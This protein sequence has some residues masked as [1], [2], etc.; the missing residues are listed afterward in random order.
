M[1]KKQDTAME[2]LKQVRRGGMSL[3]DTLSGERSM[4]NPR[5]VL[6]RGRRSRA[7]QQESLGE[8]T[9]LFGKSG[10]T[11][12]NFAR[13]MAEYALELDD[14]VE[15]HKDL[16]SNWQGALGRMRAKGVMWGLYRSMHRGF[17][18]GVPFLKTYGKN[19]MLDRAERSGGLLDSIIGDT[20]RNFTGA[21]NSIKGSLKQLQTLEADGHSHLD[22]LHEE[23]DHWRGESTRLDQVVLGAEREMETK[24]GEYDTLVSQWEQMPMLND[25]EKLARE[26]FGRSVTAAQGELQQKELT[27][28]NL[29]NERNRAD[30][31]LD[32]SENSSRA[33]EATLL[34]VQS[35]VASYEMMQIGYEAQIK[36]SMPIFQQ[37]GKT[38]ASAMH[39]T[40]LINLY[41]RTMKAANE[42]MMMNVLAARGIAHEAMEMLAKPFFDE[43]VVEQVKAYSRETQDEQRRFSNAY[44]LTQQGIYVDPAYVADP[45]KAEKPKRIDQILADIERQEKE[46]TAPQGG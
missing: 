2:D 38:A 23:S 27:V 39:A 21:G 40:R 35:L 6:E 20:I 26:E 22:Y 41:N 37:N 8:Q 44:H 25:A 13:M 31:L 4:E 7:D 14:L 33:Q 10:I 30:K 17:L 32:Q 28:N 46:E 34:T 24:K 42:V 5:D 11:V 29:R 36:Y 15:Q 1:A 3:Y 43:E 18:S 16:S 45:T 19:K 12:E 9:T